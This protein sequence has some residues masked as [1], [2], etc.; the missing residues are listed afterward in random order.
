MKLLFAVLAS[1]FLA[2][3][4]TH[5]KPSTTLN[6]PPTEAFAAFDR[7]ELKPVAL[8]PAFSEHSANQRAA[9]KIQEYF[10]GRVKPVVDGWN[11][12]KNARS[13]TL[14]IEPTI[15]QIK[16]I[17]VGARIFVG[18]MAGSSAVVMKVKYTDMTTGKVVAHPEFYQRAAAM[19]GAVTYGGQD[20]AM[21][22]RIVT[23]VA[24][25][26]ARNYG[27]RVGGANG[28]SENEEL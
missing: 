14:L 3:C 24:D 23:L 26:N 12:S 5:I 19:S 16:F 11:A 2:S 6:P 10:D 18:P 4:A 21:L 9:A 17:G 27:T 22:A 1:V 20:N 13:R 7:F 28:I 8:A 25:Y 15:E